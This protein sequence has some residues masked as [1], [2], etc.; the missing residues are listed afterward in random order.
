M[1]INSADLDVGGDGF[2]DVFIRNG[3]YGSLHC[4]QLILSGPGSKR[5]L[6]RDSIGYFTLWVADAPSLT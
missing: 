6:L 2:R 5:K 4:R 1:P 3:E